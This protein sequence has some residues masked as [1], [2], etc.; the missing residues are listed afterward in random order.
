VSILAKVRGATMLVSFSAAFVTWILTGISSD[1][2]RGAVVGAYIALAGLGV[3]LLTHLLEGTLLFGVAQGSHVPGIVSAGSMTAVP[4]GVLFWANYD[5]WAWLWL[6]GWIMILTLAYRAVWEL[7]ISRAKSRDA[8]ELA[9]SLFDRHS[10][11]RHMTAIA[12]WVAVAA[13]LAYLTLA[14]VGASKPLVIGVGIGAA[15]AVP[16]A[17]TLQY[18]LK[19]HDDRQRRRSIF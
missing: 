18:L 3:M 16:T 12:R 4:L 13:G 10:G 7:L 9:V 11:L 6:V 15:L 19:R 8:V 17:N 1:W 2:R 5:G 14:N